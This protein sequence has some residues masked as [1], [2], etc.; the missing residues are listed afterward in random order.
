MDGNN[1]KKNMKIIVILILLMLFVIYFNWSTLN[2]FIPDNPNVPNVVLSNNDRILIMAPH[3]DD[4]SIA[5]GGLIQNA[6][7]KGIPVHVV[8]L[9]NGDFNVWSYTLYEKIPMLTSSQALELG[10]IR[11]QEALNAIKELGL[12]EK[13]ATFLG[14]PDYGT[15][16]ILYY[17]WGDNPPYQSI[18]TRKTEVPYSKALSPGAPYKGE[19]IMKDIEA[20]IN[21]FGPTKIFV[22]HPDDHHPDHRAM[23]VFT[24][25]SLWE[26]RKEVEIY[27]YVVHYRNW[28]LPLGYHPNYFLDPPSYDYG[29]VWKEL[30][31]KSRNVQTKF[32]ALKK[33]V[34]QYE[35]NKKYLNSFI[36]TNEVYGNFEDISLGITQVDISLNKNEIQKSPPQEFN[37]S[38]KDAFVR[39]EAQS[40]KIENDKLVLRYAISEPFKERTDLFVYVYGYKHD[41]DF[42]KMPKINIKVGLNNYGVYDQK[43]PIPKEN[44]EVKKT[45]T[46]IIIKI[47]LK[48]IGNPDKILFS[49]RTAMGPLSLDLMPWRIGII[50]TDGQER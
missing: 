40:A 4:E 41:T 16:E 17:H 15:S 50:D 27:P 45:P 28:P 5:T 46:E 11:R 43:I 26:I 1:L 38:Q 14:Y 49:A 36:R 20:V 22:S 8:F 37:D 13:D 30:P 2:P 6:I 3:P 44:C 7:D 21:D 10:E 23:F 33:H 24:I 42:S 29:I 18:L 35:A 12:S 39:I 48:I 31:I 32:S 34:T 9:T 47:P 19:S 25:V